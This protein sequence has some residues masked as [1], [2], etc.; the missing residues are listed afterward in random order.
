MI[1]FPAA[2][3]SKRSSVFSLITLVLF[4]FKIPRLAQ[5]L[6][7]ATGQRKQNIRALLPENQ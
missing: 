7:L 2:Y 4:W 3:S 5:L 6:I 1:S